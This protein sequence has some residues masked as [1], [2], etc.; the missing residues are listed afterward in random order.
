[1]KQTL[2]ENQGIPKGLLYT[3]ATIAGISVANLYYNQPL[4][5]VMRIDLKCSEMDTNHIALLT[6]IGYA[7]GLL[8]IIPLGDL[9]SRK[10]IILTNFSLLVASLLCIASAQSIHI[11]HLAS[12]ITGACSVIPQI[13]VPWQ[14]N[15]PSRK[16]K[17]RMWDSSS[18][19]CSRVFWPHGSSADMLANGWDGA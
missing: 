18:L 10:R 4:L 19:V 3:L 7:L 16:I 6:Q 8:F 12:V 5:D 11:I 14:L 9:Y 17:E 15:I 1:M 2:L 13:F